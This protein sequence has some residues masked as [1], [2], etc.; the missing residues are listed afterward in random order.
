MKK[1]SS[2][3]VCMVFST[4]V[5]EAEGTYLGHLQDLLQLANEEDLL[6]AVGDRPVLQQRLEHRL[7]QLGILLHKLH[8]G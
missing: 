4:W 6:L 8:H 1:P 2:Q 5:N 3:T 7:R